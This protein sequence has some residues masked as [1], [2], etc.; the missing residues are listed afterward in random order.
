MA[1]VLL[2]QLQVG[3]N[4]TYSYMFHCLFEYNCMNNLH[5]IVYHRDILVLLVVM[6]DT[7]IR[8]YIVNCIHNCIADDN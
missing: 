7:G 3:D 8:D 2:A 1:L 5:H 6:V 4:Y